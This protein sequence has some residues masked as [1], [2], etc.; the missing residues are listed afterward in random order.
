MVEV[1][2]E[3]ERRHSLLLI[4]SWLWGNSPY[5]DVGSSYV[6]E[7]T[8]WTVLYKLALLDNTLMEDH[9]NGLMG[10]KVVIT[11]EG[12]VWK[13]G[14]VCY[15]RLGLGTVSLLGTLRRKQPICY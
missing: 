11:R 10:S 7:F 15:Q 4:P 6:Y 2:W 8:N 14:C 3:K 1:L 13:R 5:F 9:D 12:N